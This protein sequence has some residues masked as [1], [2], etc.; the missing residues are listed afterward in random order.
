MRILQSIEDILKKPYLMFFSLIVFFTPLIFTYTT[1]EIFE[2]PK[3]LFIY[4]LGFFTIAFFLSEWLFTRTKLRFPNKY[5]CFFVSIIFISTIFSSHLYTSFFGYYTRFN[6]GALSYLVFFGLYFVGINRLSKKDMQSLIKISMFT[7]LP[8]SFYGLAQYFGGTDRVFSTLG[9]PNWLAQYLS[10][11]LPIV[12]Y[13]LLIDEKR[14]FKIW[15]L[16]YTFGYFCLWVSYSMSGVLGFA[17]GIVVLG[18][19][20]Y[21]SRKFNDEFLKRLLLVTAISFFISIFNLGIFKDKVSDVFIDLQ[22]QSLLV[23]R[24]YAEGVYKL[25]DPGYIRLELWK[26]TLR[27]IV[28][29]PKIF[30]LGTGPETFPYVFQ[31]FRSSSLNYSSEWD[32]VFNKPH[33]YY[34]EL[35]VESG[36]FSVVAFAL[37]LYQIIKKLPDYI[38]PSVVV[39]AVT[40]FFGWPVVATSTL[41]WMFLIFADKNYEESS[42]DLIKTSV[43]RW[44]KYTKLLLLLLIW[45]GYLFIFK[46]STSFYKADAD[47]KESQDIIKAGDLD[48]SIYLVNR[49]IEL[50]PLEPNY[51]RGRAKINTVSLVSTGDIEKVK[52]SIYLDLK[53]ADELNPSNLVTLR[54]SVPIYYFLAVRDFYSV[55]GPD[56]HDPKYFGIVS[57]FY[58][59][60]KRDY[61]NDIGVLLSVAKYEKKL[62]ME[63]AYNET[64]IRVKELRP[65][66]LEWHELFR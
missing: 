62:G 5:V 25:S 29:S 7:I 9:Q 52:E 20:L 13:F 53:K 12:L 47:F 65:D 14:N 46:I 34:L 3:M 57:D 8:V 2:F 35:W 32:Y 45:A 17:A 1:N 4:I 21:K 64:V 19:K 40:N 39:F 37:V 15:F 48:K 60:V 28:S 22:K 27:L 66:I 51:Y 26:S 49:S 50:N 55:P 38:L 33:N 6:G 18:V 23:K 63:D 31:A 41:F 59:K 10:M 43:G 61:W 56:N 11:L 42:Q 44:E 24:V 36:L 58:S 54:N 16:I 30:L